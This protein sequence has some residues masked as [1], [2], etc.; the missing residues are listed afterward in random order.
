MAFP[1]GGGGFGEGGFGMPGFGMPMM[2][3]R[4]APRFHALALLR[5]GQCCPTRS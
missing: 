4:C 1:Y 3:G 5:P 2:G